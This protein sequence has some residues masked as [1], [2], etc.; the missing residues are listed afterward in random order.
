MGNGLN[1]IQA[2]VGGFGNEINVV[3][4]N[5]YYAFNRG[6]V[7]ANDLF[8]S[9]NLFDVRFSGSIVEDNFESNSGVNEF[10]NFDTDLPGNSASVR[11]SGVKDFGGA[12][13]HVVVA[14]GSSVEF[15]GTFHAFFQR[16]E[17][18]GDPSLQQYFKK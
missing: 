6:V 5:D 9:G 15:A 7:R 18:V 2:L 16:N 8:G 3:S 17:L 12:P 14:P 4:H 13:H 11:V 10:A 1:A